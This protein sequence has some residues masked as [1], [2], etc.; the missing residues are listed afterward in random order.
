MS[1]G[2]KICPECNG[3]VRVYFDGDGSCSGTC[4]TCG[5][6][7]DCSPP[8]WPSRIPDEGAFYEV[9]IT[10]P[11]V[12]TYKLDLSDAE[13]LAIY[14]N[15]LQAHNRAAEVTDI[16]ERG[17]CHTLAYIRKWNHARTEYEYMR[18]EHIR[19]ALA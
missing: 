19:R 8:E 11:D 18:P 2:S 14:T 5:R 7:I 1:Y 16:D 13:S 4:P 10:H 3:E 9:V 6:V 15:V 17:E 12:R